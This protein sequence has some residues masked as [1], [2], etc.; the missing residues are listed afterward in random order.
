MKIAQITPGLLPIP[1]NGWGAVEKIIWDYKKNFEKLGHTCDIKYLDNI[2][3]GDYDIV[4]IHM[5]NLGVEAS[6]KKIPFIFTMHDHHSFFLGKDS[7]VYKENLKAINKSSKTFVPARYLVDYFNSGENLCYVPHGVDSDF[8]SPAKKIN[9]SKILCVGNNGLIGDPLF[10]RKGFIFAIEAAR[11]LNLP[12]TIAGPSQNKHFF[13]NNKDFIPYDKLT[14]LYDINEEDLKK[15]YQTHSVFL[16]PSMLEA[17]HPNLTLMEA[18]SCGL[19][20]ISCYED[21]PL[22]GMIKIVR[23]SDSICKAV[24]QAEQDSSLREKA[25]KYARDNDWNFVCK[26]IL[27]L[28]KETF[29]M[30]GLLLKNYR[31]VVQDKTKSTPV[32]NKILISFNDGPKV[33]AKGTSEE[34]YQIEFI[35]DNKIEYRSVIGIDGWAAANKKYF[36][37]WK[38]KV[39]ELKN[40]KATEILFDAT[41]RKIQ[42][43]NDSGSLGDLI[44][45]MPFVDL[46]QKK[47]N[48]IV[49]FYT[50]KKE[51]FNSSYPNINFFNY[52]DVRQ[53]DHYAKFMLGCFSSANFLDYS[54]NNFRDQPLQKIAADILGIGYKEVR[55]N[56]LVENKKRPIEQ[57]YVC[58]STNSTA[59]AKLWNNEGGWK[60]VVEYLK[61][62]GYEVVAIQKEEL[63]ESKIQDVTHPPTPNIQDAITWI[64]HAEF[65]IGLGSGISW[66][67][68]ALKKEVILI[69]GFSL[70]ESEF[71]TPYRVINKSESV[72]HGCW[73]DPSLQFD[74][75]DW[76]WC[77]KQKGSARQFECS[78]EITFEMVKEKIDL[79]ILNLAS[80]QKN[81]HSSDTESGLKT[82]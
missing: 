20:V 76:D 25:I 30:R 46:F 6:L 66:L 43:I 75:S 8:F 68:W 19:P 31:K 80:A 4:H 12:I 47:H 37:N 53:S 70:P 42:I 67:S 34:K 36:I 40:S 14:L 15:A 44:A 58:I 26:R 28:Y 77:P 22:P 52:N 74:K 32:L 48:C 21:E 61:S 63:D 45:W 54:P 2:K 9:S 72:C 57:K 27:N 29:S 1:P 50:P 78:K 16:H 24:A 65:Y 35:N 82:Y 41:G 13:E 17:G 55:P 5:A 33:E 18:M 56:V 69:S 49:D 71:F 51:L 38:I 79:C 39:T 10:D 81:L 62:C 3:Q 11:K 64:N 59:R 23:S 60:K 7:S 73:N